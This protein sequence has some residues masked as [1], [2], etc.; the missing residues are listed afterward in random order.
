MYTRCFSRTNDEDFVSELEFIWPLRHLIFDRSI[1]NMTIYNITQ[2]KDE[3]DKEEW[4]NIRY[5][6]VDTHTISF[7]YLK[8]SAYTSAPY[9]NVCLNRNQFT[10]IDIPV[11]IK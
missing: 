10:I 2:L 4:C 7:S 5:V 6:N 3:I 11:E 1:V 8:Y 9:W